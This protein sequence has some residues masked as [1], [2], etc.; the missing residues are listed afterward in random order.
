M[1]LEERGGGGVQY[2][3]KGGEAEVRMYYMKEE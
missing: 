1:D 3:R 2:R